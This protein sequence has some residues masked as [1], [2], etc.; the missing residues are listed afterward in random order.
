M[1]K[2]KMV[3]DRQTIQVA[4]DQ[5]YRECYLEGAIELIKG[6]SNVF[7]KKCSL[8][9]KKLPSGE[10]IIVSS[11]NY[12]MQEGFIFQLC[13]F[14]NESPFYLGGSTDPYVMVVVMQ[15]YL[16]AISSGWRVNSSLHQSQ[17]YGEY[18]NWGPGAIK[19]QFSQPHKLS[20]DK[21]NNLPLIFVYWIM[22][23]GSPKMYQLI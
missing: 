6:T 8:I 15:S 11:T 12:Q 2:V 20:K 14:L 23:G 3:S 17:F 16:D 1:Y 19:M 7:F 13:S 4:D 10:T 9:S 18:E 21:L 22:N 5:F